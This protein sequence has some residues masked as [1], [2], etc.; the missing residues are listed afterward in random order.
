MPNAD[1]NTDQSADTDAEDST[2]TSREL[3]LTAP[4]V[5]RLRDH[6]LQDDEKERIAFGYCTQSGHDYLLDELT[7]VPDEDHAVSTEAACRADTAVERE[8]VTAC[9]STDRHLCIIHSHPF[10]DAATFSPT[11]NDLMA[12][13]RDWLQPLYPD[14]HLLFGVLGRD[15]LRIQRLTEDGDFTPLA[16]TVLGDWI[17]DRPLQTRQANSAEVRN[18]DWQRYDRIIRAIGLDGQ[19]RLADTHVA[20][21]GCGGIGSYLATGLARLGV[22]TLTLIDP[23][24]VERSNLP[25]LNG[26][27]LGDIGHAKVQVMQEQCWIAN[28]DIAV[29]TV[30]DRVQEAADQL[31]D[32]DL[33]VAG[34]DRLTPRH[35][36]NEF[37]TRHLI[38]YIDAGTVIDLDDS[39]EHVA[40]EHAFIQTVVPGVTGCFDCLNRGNPDRLRLEHQ[41]DAERLADLDAGYI[42]GTDLTPEAAVLPLN[43][44]AVAATLNTVVDLVTGRRP[45]TAFLRL[46][47]VGNERVPLQTRPA[48]ECVTCGDT[49]LLAAGETRDAV[50]PD[51]DPEVDELSVPDTGRA[52]DL[53][54][55]DDA[56]TE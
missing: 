36:L 47:Q 22:G 31:R 27:R 10:D 33:V 2:S 26:A 49:G 53:F 37:C 6:L 4:Q 34:L 15:N 29:T 40:T 20:V 35:W 24:D 5:Q 17:L 1:A 13:F 9:A 3:R 41:D 44:T 56:D 7:M 50:G 14:T 25:R 11:D 51:S 55:D 19:H 45:P 16:V 39:D 43:L 38:P 32:V 28:P 54:A 46:E 23:D 21:V 30:Y 48:A 8:Q 52:G 42:T 12:R 18:V